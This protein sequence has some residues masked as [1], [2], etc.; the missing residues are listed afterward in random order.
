MADKLLITGFVLLFIGLTLKYG[1]P[2]VYANVSSTQSKAS[3]TFRFW[4]QS[5]GKEQKRKLLESF[6]S[7]I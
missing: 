6:L 3:F 2:L 5:L 7:N 1:Y 4:F